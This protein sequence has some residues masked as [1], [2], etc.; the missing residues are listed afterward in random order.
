VKNAPLI[1]P[2]AGRVKVRV[3][4]TDAELMIARSVTRV[5]HLGSHRKT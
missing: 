2:A 5:L 4:R 1:L 3:I